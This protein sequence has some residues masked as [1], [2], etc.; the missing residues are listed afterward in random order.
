MEEPERNG[1][2][3]FEKV[4]TEKTHL[5]DVESHVT[6]NWWVPDDQ[7]SGTYRITYYG[8]SMDNSGTVT[9]FT[10]HSSPFKIAN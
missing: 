6:I 7:P 4:S 3:R 8:D 1:V 9:S 10:G 2:L 5:P